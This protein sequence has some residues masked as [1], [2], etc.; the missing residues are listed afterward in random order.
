MTKKM[1]AAAVTIRKGLKAKVSR[2]ANDKIKVTR[3]VSDNDEF[4]Q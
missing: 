3:E 4:V 2:M 1:K